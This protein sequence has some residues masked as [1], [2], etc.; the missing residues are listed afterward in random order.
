MHFISYKATMAKEE[1]YSHGRLLLSIN[2]NSQD[3]SGSGTTSQRFF[4]LGLV[5]FFLEV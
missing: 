4:L 2:L 1:E 5:W 3:R